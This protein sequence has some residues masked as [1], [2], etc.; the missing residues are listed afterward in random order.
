MKQVLRPFQEQTTQSQIAPVEQV[1]VVV[2]LGIG[3]PLRASKG[4]LSAWQKS[5]ASSP[6]IPIRQIGVPVILKITCFP[7]E[8]QYP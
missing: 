7:Q 2:G 8:I 4:R 1:F 3:K 5:R 6:I